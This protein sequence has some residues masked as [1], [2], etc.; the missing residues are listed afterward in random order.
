MRTCYQ[1]IPLAGDHPAQM[2]GNHPSRAVPAQARP[3]LAGTLE[4]VAAVLDGQSGHVG[5]PGRAATGWLHCADLLADGRLDRELQAMS[6]AYGYSREVSATHFLSAYV[7]G[8]AG[9]A[10]AAY[11]V[12]SRV[13]DVC[14]HDMS[15]H[16]A[17]GGWFDATAFHSERVTMLTDDPALLVTVV[18]AT[19]DRRHDPV[20]DRMT[21]RMIDV[22]ADRDALRQRL[23]TALVGHLEPLVVTLRAQARLGL[24]A[25]WGMVAA[26]CGRTFLL[27]ERVTRDPDIGRAEADA[28]F[29]LASPP[30]RARPAWFEFTHRG[31]RQTAMRRG[32]CCLAHRMT[33]QYCTTCPFTPDSERELRLRAWIDTQ[34][35]GGLAIG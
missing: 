9:L 20:S 19:D 3:L 17:P 30:M 32:S 22:V 28:F 15:L 27:T 34:G 25:L 6:D 31:R 23:V 5:H 8:V 26:Q 18:P 13:P 14:A 7:S 1:H 10:I 2:V 29:A 21:D 33:S 35:D 12:H 11:M 16:V 24:S 4:A